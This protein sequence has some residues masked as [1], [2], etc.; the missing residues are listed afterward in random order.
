MYTY[1]CLFTYICMCVYIPLYVCGYV[2]TTGRTALVNTE[3]SMS[4]CW[5]FAR[6]P[7]ALCG[8]CVCVCVCVCGVCVCVCVWWL[9]WG[10]GVRQSL[11]ERLL[12]SFAPQER[13]RT[14]KGYPVIACSK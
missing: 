5:A 14:Q 6:C 9:R 12:G 3:L 13:E 2:F 1:K 4:M 10:E 7:A 8:G 11:T